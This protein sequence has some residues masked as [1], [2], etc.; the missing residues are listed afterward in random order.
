M[1]DIFQTTKDL[2]K[3]FYVT[4]ELG[5]TINVLDAAYALAVGQS[6]GNPNLRSLYETDEMIDTYCAK[7]IQ[8]DSF[9]QKLGI[10]EIGFPLENIDFNTDGISQLLCMIA[11]GQSDI[12]SIT[13][14]RAIRI[15]MSDNIIS[16]YFLKPKY[17]L[18]GFRKL[19]N[20]YNKP[21]FGSII[22]PKTGITP[23][24][25]LD[26]VKEL[27]DGGTDFIKEDEILS[28]PAI[29]R[30]EDRVELIS[31]YIQNTNVVYTFCINSDPAYILDRA[32]F[33]VNNGGNG[34]H[35]NVWSGLGTFKNIRELDLDLFIHYQ[36]SG[37]AFFTHKNNPFS[38][39]W[40]LLCQ[41]AVWSGVDTI[42]AGMWGGYLSEPENELKETLKI[43]VDGN[44][45]PALSCGMNA[46]LIQPIVD[47]FGIDWMANVG[48]A[49][50]SHPDGSEAG[51]RKIRNAIESIL[52]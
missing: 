3:Y 41:L 11:G 44:V 32:K 33:V 22:K 6:I 25:L 34:V 15:D 18:T 42:H 7:I 40:Q 16:K 46:D 12:H 49:I 47:K 28:N 50:H 45:T 17:G 5:S 9:E 21:L 51:A 39:S 4:Y 14:C 20:Q 26:M 38:I 35:V 8:S 19:T 2:S 29:C 36:R 13:R 43:L 52:K 27:V 30:L 10:V 24:T 23:A 48:G 1:L 37:E 31:N